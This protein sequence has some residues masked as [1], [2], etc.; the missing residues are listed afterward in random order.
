MPREACPSRVSGQPP[1]STH[2]WWAG[3][4][5]HLDAAPL[6]SHLPTQGTAAPLKTSSLVCCTQCKARG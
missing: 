4:P 3:A 6:P 5:S 1:L 2:L